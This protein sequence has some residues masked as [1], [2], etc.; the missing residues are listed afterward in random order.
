MQHDLVPTALDQAWLGDPPLRFE[1]GGARVTRP[2]PFGSPLHLAGLDRDDVIVSID[3]REVSSAGR[4]SETRD[5]LLP[6]RSVT[7]TF[8]RA[9]ELLTARV[10]P[11]EHPGLRLV[12]FEEIGRTLTSSHMR[13]REAWLG[14]QLD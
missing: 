12:A 2:M 10:T 13:F 14:S 11:E 7:L 5:R 3:G 4:W 1:R 9:G 6:G 8:A